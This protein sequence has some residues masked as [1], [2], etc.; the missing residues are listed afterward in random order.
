MEESPSASV[1]P[2]SPITY[3]TGYMPQKIGRS[4]CQQGTDSQVEK[5]VCVEKTVNSTLFLDVDWPAVMGLARRAL[6]WILSLSCWAQTATR[7][8]LKSSAPSRPNVVLITLDTTRADRMG[9]LGS[10]R[11]L[12]PN[13]DA[14]AHVALVFSRAYAQ[15]PLTTP[16]HATIFTGTYPQFNHVNY[17]GDPLGKSLPFLPDILHRNGYKTA[18]FVG[19]L[20]LDPTKLASGFDRGFDVYDAGFHRRR[21]GEDNYHSLERR[22]EEVLSRAI[23]WLSKHPTGP[24]FLWVH[25]YDPHDPYTPPEPYRTQYKAEPYDG[26]I[27]YT[28]SIVGKL[29]SELRTRGLF[30][31]CLIAI[32]ADHGEA[33]GEHGEQ[34]H[35]I[36]LYDETIHVPLMFKLPRQNSGTKVETRVGLVDVAPSILRAAHLSVPDVMQGQSLLHFMMPDKAVRSGHQSDLSSQRAIY[37]ESGYGHLSFGWSILKAW[38]AGNYLYVDAPEREL[39]D[40]IADPGATHNLASDSRAVADTAAAQ[41]AEFRRKT[42]AESMEK[43]QLTAEQ[44]ES[45]HALG[46]MGSDSAAPDDSNDGRGADPKQKIAIAN[47]LYEAMVQTENGRYQE[48][49]PSLEEVVKQEHHALSA[50]LLLGRAYVSLK[51]YQKAIAPLQHVVQTTPDNS[52]ARYELGCALVKTGRWNEAAPQFEAAVSEMNSSAMMHFYLALVYQQTSRN[53]EA[54]AEFKDALRWD[55]KNFPANLLLGRMYIKQQK[56]ADALPL[57]QRAAALRPD[58]IDPHRLLADAYAQLRREGEASR[59]L[60]EAERIQAQG[61]SRLGTPRED[62]TED[63]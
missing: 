11:G 7:A 51:E 34:H 9:F 8:T 40:Q 3:E 43:T 52:L 29:L 4:I 31:G 36:F 26:E 60:S 23:A 6:P 13:L 30:D 37:S 45:L 19:A 42:V 57:L 21:P 48:A 32:M 14:L 53:D 22:G 12:T 18:A 46:Y 47:L 28:D 50:Y 1:A 20:V 38:R 62:H 35:G 16:S 15:V 39:Y 58:A 49:V 17:M 5:T 2:R 24:F 44:T 54:L 10:D 63:K 59:E 56:A 27:A 41:M 61:G 33:F 25:L 55:P